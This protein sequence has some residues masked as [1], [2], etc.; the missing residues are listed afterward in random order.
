MSGKLD[1]NDIDLT[2][3]EEVVKNIIK[4]ISYETK[5]IID[6]KI[7]EYTGNIFSYTKNPYKSLGIA[8]GELSTEVDIQKSLGKQHVEVSKFE[9]YLEI[10]IY[11]QY[12]YRICYIKHGIGNYPVTVVLEQ[13]IA[14][15][16]LAEINANYII[17]CD[18]RD[19]FEKLLI[20]IIT[21]K[22]VI[23]IMQEMIRI[24]QIQKQYPQNNEDSKTSS[25]AS[26]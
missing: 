6:G 11:E 20:Q 22:H 7:K 24:N 3:P 12:K 19:D 9:F 18:N 25:E 13:G 26:E 23:S 2:P 4:Q 10:P 8:L 15:E 16:V 17:K 21:S 14:D 1:F 5:G